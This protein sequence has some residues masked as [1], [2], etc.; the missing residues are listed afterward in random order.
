MSERELDAYQVKLE[1]RTKKLTDYE[2][3]V[4]SRLTACPETTSAPV[5]DWLKEYSPVFEDV[6]LSQIHYRKEYFC[7]TLL[8]F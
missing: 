6:T 4:Y 3:F 5:N 8:F 7:I 1:Q 2:D